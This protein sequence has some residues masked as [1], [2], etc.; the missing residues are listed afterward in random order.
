[1]TGNKKL[2]IV[3]PTFNRVESCV[4]CIESIYKQIYNNSKII[5]VDDN[6]SDNTADIIR[7]KFPEVTV[8]HGTGDL[9][10]TG[11][12]NMGCEYA[13]KNGAKLI[14][15]M[16]DDLILDLHYLEQMINGHRQYPRALI[17]SLSVSMEKVPR[18]IDAGNVTCNFWTGK[19]KNRGNLFS[20]YKFDLKG[21]VPS[22]SLTGRG[23]LIPKE[24]FEKIGLFDFNNFPHYAADNDFSLRAKKAGFE[25]MINLD[26][27]I[28][29]NIQTSGYIKYGLKQSFTTILISFFKFKSPNNLRKNFIYLKRHYPKKY[30]FYFPI[31]FVI[32]QFRIL[33]GSLKH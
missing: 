31:Y 26:C 13:L 12:T 19:T 32:C 8:L 23:T 5:I 2:H 18:L 29:S 25:I 16:N 17:G 33:L 21:I 15:T 27:I 14:L 11:A 24:V 3:I 20:P 10:W 4:K 1:M 30:I 28:Y 6:S 22:I 9:W 7:S